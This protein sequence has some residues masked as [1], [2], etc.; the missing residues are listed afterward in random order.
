MVKKR[1]QYPESF[2]KDAVQLAQSSSKAKAQIARELGISESVL[3]RWIAQYGQTDQ[4]KA[5]LGDERELKR[6][7]KQLR[8]EN[9]RLRQERDILKKAISIFSQQQP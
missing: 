8:K 2:K 6:E 7:L 3:Y 4:N 5:D 1:K 9:E